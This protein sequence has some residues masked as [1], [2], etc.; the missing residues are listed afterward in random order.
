MWRLLSID[1]SLMVE[2][3]WLVSWILWGWNFCPSAAP[4]RFAMMDE[5]LTRIPFWI[6]LKSE[7]IDWSNWKRIKIIISFQQIKKA[8][9]VFKKLASTRNHFGA[10]RPRQK[11]SSHVSTLIRETG[12]FVGDGAHQPRHSKASGIWAHIMLLLSPPV[13]ICTTRSLASLP[14][15]IGRAKGNPYLSAY[16][17]ITC[18]RPLLSVT[19]FSPKKPETI[20]I[21][22][23]SISIALFVTCFLYVP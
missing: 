9:D 22:A 19:V 16:L 23:W 4:F 2:W 13:E 15:Y 1:W 21:T 20:Q 18:A 12:V 14:S 10:H 7:L 8:G 6:D 3:F 11:C 17:R 5:P